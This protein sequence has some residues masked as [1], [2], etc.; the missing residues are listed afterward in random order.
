MRILQSMYF[1][2]A[3]MSWFVQGSDSKIYEFLCLV[4]EPLIHPKAEK[5]SFTSDENQEPESVQIILRTAEISLDDDD[6]VLDAETE[7]ASQ[8]PLRRIWIVIVK[9]WKAFVEIFRNR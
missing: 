7:A 6:E 1:A 4:T 5:V 9:M 2:R 8:S 3:I